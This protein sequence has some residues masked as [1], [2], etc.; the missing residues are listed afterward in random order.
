MDSVKFFTEVCNKLQF[1]HESSSK[2]R[3]NNIVLK[4]LNTLF[5][6][7]HERIVSTEQ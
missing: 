6:K 3:F 2:Y 7:Y 1:L 5:N 4:L